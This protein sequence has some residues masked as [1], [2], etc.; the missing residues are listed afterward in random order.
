M[1]KINNTT[2]LLKPA[3]K[4]RNP[5][6]KCDY[7]P[8]KGLNQYYDSLMKMISLF[9]Y[10]FFCTKTKGFNIIINK[11]FKLAKKN[12]KTTNPNL[13]NCKY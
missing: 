10:I 12:Y 3:T 2:K 1:T 8:L 6:K 11:T 4:E 7:K 13:Q 9:Q 5:L